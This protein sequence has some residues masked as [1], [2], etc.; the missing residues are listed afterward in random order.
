MSN[1]RIPEEHQQ[2]FVAISMLSDS[3]V[4]ELF[5][6]LETVPL[7]LEQKSAVEKALNNS[8]YDFPTNVFDIVN[9]L[10]SIY[11]AL[12]YTNKTIEVFVTDIVESIDNIQI[13][14]YTYTSKEKGNLRKNLTTLLSISSISTVSKATGV[15][16]DCE[17]ILRNARILTDIRP[18]FGYGED[19]SILAS[20]IVQTLKLE[21][22][23]DDEEKEFFINLDEQDIDNLIGIL[24]RAKR[25]SDQ[26][27]NLLKKARVPCIPVVEK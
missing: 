19:D 15:L 22:V 16:F 18:I 24:Q 26:S 23:K 17:N 7:A 10:F 1:I 20:V 3:V 14:G 13:E 4:T 27:K 11:S 21:F 25:K 2:S 9:V 8:T 5:S 6:I 12:A